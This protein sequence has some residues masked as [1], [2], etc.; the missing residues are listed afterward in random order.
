MLWYTF[1]YHPSLYTNLQLCQY[2]HKYSYSLGTHQ[3]LFINDVMLFMRGGGGFEPPILICP[4]KSLF[5]WPFG[6]IAFNGLIPKLPNISFCRR[7]GPPPLSLKIIFWRTLTPPSV[8]DII[9]KQ[10]LNQQSLVSKHCSALL[11]P[12]RWRQQ[13]L[14]QAGLSYSYISPVLC[15]L[16][17]YH[18]CTVLSYL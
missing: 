15:Y 7:G 6:W 14:A 4:R 11:Y 9:N 18:I 5:G 17:Y 16:L 1:Y 10:P 3:S 12:R 13:I 2:K 8:H